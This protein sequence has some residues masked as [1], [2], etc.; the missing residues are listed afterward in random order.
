MQEFR[1]IIVHGIRRE[2][3]KVKKLKQVKIIVQTQKRLT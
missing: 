1:R 3:I 2:E